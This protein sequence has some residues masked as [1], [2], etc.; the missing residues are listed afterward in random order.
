[1]E[2][3]TCKSYEEVMLEIYRKQRPGEPPTLDTAENLMQ[4]LSFDPRRYDLSTVGRYKFNKKLT[5]WWLYTLAPNSSSF[6][7]RNSPQALW[8]AVLGT[9]G[10][11]SAWVCIC[12]LY[13]SSR[14]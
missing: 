4:G 3:D 8:A 6:L 10:P 1:M 7:A 5:L 9:R 14:I 11:K 2:K 12:L 13:T